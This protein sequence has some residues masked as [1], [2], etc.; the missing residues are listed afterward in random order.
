VTFAPTIELTADGSATLRSP[1]NGDTY[2]STRGAVGESRHVFIENG[3]LAT[4]CDSVAVLEVGF[5]SGLNAW[6]TLLESRRQAR[7]VEYTAVELYPVPSDVVEQLG[8]TSDARFAAM[9]T[10]EWGGWV[11]ICGGF[12]LRKLNVDVTK[13]AFSKGA[14]DVVY[15]DA[16]APDTP[17]EMWTQSLFSAIYDAMNHGG[18]LVTYSAKGDVRRAMQSAGFKVEKLPGALGKRHMLRATKI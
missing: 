1:L 11:E 14:F 7:T 3:F 4:G 2:H 8:Y 13:E 16:F 9:H 15:F 5:G 6:L 12:T 17:P 18:V 10:A